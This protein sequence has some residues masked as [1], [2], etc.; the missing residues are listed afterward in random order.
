MKHTRLYK[1]F[2]LVI[3]LSML[4]AACGPAATEAP[5]EEAAPPTE[6]MAEPTEVMEEP[7]EVMEEPTEV[8]EPTEP[9]V[10]EKVTVIIGTTDAISSLDPADAYAVHDWELIKNTGEGLLKWAP[11]TAELQTGLAVDLPEISE[12]GL[13]YTFKLRPGITFADGLELTAPM[14]AEQFNRLLTIGPGETCPNGVASALAVPYVQ[15]FAAPDDETLV[16][17]LKTPVGF[18]S[19]V[20]ASA[21]YIPAHPDI[22]LADTCVLFPEAPIY[23][24][25]PWFI[26]QVTYAEQV[27]L[28]PN[29]YYNGDLVPQVDQIIIRYFADPQTMSLAV[30]NGE[31]DIAWRFLGPELISGLEQVADLSVNKIDAGPIRYLIINHTFP[32][33]DDS[34]VRKAVAA[35]IDR[36][37]ISDVVYSGQAAPLF[38]QVPPGF[39][40]ATEVFDDM[41]ASPDIDLANEFL[42]ASGYTADNPLQ[43]ELWYPPEHYGSETAAW[44]EVIQQQL[45]ATGAIDVTLQA[46]E[47]STYITALTGGESYPAGVLGWFFDYPDSSNYLDPFVFNG[48]L[49][50]NVALAAEGSDY[51][52]PIDDTAAELVDL[53][54]QA[55][56]ESDVDAR[57]A[58]Y[59][60]AQEVYADLVVTLP[61]FIIAEHV[62]YRPGIAGTDMYA[63]PGTLNIGPTL[64]FNY[65]TI[66]KSP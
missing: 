24:V 31:I 16:I 6:E 22:F 51:G 60:Q 11:G 8:A 18:F 57:A 59:E 21:T 34:N 53:L 2:A 64:E 3:M 61:L 25:G 20:M 23:G 5:T 33:M 32:P 49:G 65:S 28:E 17:T 36:D 9:P 4:L 1:L 62:T 37:E 39:L 66:T 15:G 14:L 7:T 27:V 47:W 40:G 43:L 54:A 26:S 30:Q 44:M 29:P 42:A 13:V 63:T 12:D 55:D 45:E 50:T 35:A 46:Q 10:E 52:E 48:G 38:S 58:L 19:Q 41:Y 56:V